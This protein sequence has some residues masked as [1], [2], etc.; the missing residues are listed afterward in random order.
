MAKHA[1][2]SSA[3]SLRMM[4]NLVPSLVATD[5]SII[6]RRIQETTLIPWPEVTGGADGAAVDESMMLV[7]RG[8]QAAIVETWGTFLVK[9][10]RK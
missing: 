10:K 2:P 8:S 3:S 7:A 6:H 5:K 1:T 4:V 9:R